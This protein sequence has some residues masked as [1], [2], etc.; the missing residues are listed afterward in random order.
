[1]YYLNLFVCYFNICYILVLYI[2]CMCTIFTLYLNAFLKNKLYIFELINIKILII[3]IFTWL[4]NNTTC[5][6]PIAAETTK[7]TR[8]KG[9]RGGRGARARGRGS[10]GG[11]AS[12]TANQRTIQESMII[13]DSDSDARPT[14]VKP[15]KTTEPKLSIMF[16]V[17]FL[18]TIHCNLY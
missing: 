11:R 3:I 16:V 15:A 17:M 9:S 2:I 1:M 18:Y 12:K 4:C 8:G 14:R 6:P 7:P 5:L 13:S 10:R